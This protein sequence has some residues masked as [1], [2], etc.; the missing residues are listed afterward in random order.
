[1]GVDLGALF[2]WSYIFPLLIF[3]TLVGLAIYKSRYRK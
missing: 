2:F 3:V 1:M